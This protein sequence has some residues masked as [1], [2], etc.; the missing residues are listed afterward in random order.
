MNLEPGDCTGVEAFL[1]GVNEAEGLRRV[2]GEVQSFNL[3]GE[4]LPF[5]KSQ[6][7]RVFYEPYYEVPEGL[8]ELSELPEHIPEL[9]N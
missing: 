7:G 5:Y 8:P 2:L 4:I 6:V 3:F 1:R 9:G